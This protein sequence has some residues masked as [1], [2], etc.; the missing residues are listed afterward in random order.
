MPG[1]GGAKVTLREALLAARRSLA[2]EDR[3][4]RSR[5]IASRLAQLPVFGRARTL[6]LYAA[7]GAEVDTGEL[8]RLAAA[9]GKRV[10]F[11]RIVSPERALAYAA[12]APDAL[13]PGPAGTREPP[14][15]APHV[16]LAELD[17]VVVPG[18]AFDGRGGRLGRGRGHYDA[19]LAALPPH[20]A[21]VGVAFEL[22]IIADVPAEPHDAP[23]D[24]VVTEARVLFPLT[25]SPDSG[26][27]RRP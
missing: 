11:P 23:L 9:A 16:P 25:R 15:D 19:T 24:A 14:P 6:G 22:Q 27:A 26:M 8:A 7:M 12:C 17:L 10:A 2:P 4:D 21:R 20:A 13:V 3:L 5:S 1:A 18:V